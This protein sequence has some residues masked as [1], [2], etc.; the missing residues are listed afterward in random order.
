MTF[1]GL[2]RSRRS[3]RSATPR[4]HTSLR[5]HPIVGPGLPLLMAA[6]KGVAGHAALFLVVPSLPV[7][8]I[9]ATFAIGRQLGSAS[10]GLSAAWLLAT[11]PAFLTMSKEPMS[12][13]PAAAFW[14]LATWKV[15]DD[16]RFSKA[17]AGLAAA[18]A[19]LI[20][21]NLVPLAAVLGVWMLARQR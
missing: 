2:S 12:D 18:M 20:R 13:V 9:W 10:L 17:L 15:L 8:L 19:I 7:L 4:S 6:M 16:S 11:S 3:S 1:P 21:P 14:A 5:S